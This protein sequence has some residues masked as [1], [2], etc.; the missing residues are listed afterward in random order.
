MDILYLVAEH[1]PHTHP[2]ICH[3]PWEGWAKLITCSDAR[4]CWVDIGG[5]AHS[6]C[7]A[8]SE[9]TLDCKRYHGQYQAVLA[10]LPSLS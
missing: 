1:W 2:S 3:L 8:V 7:K 10:T 6:I 4:W 9:Y 5:V